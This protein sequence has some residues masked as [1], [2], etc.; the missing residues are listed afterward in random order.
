MR[1]TGFHSEYRIKDFE[2]GDVELT[3]HSY[4]DGKLVETLEIYSGP[5]R[6]R[7][8]AALNKLMTD[9]EAYGRKDARK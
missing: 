3:C 5:D 8:V 2:N 7:M 6:P 9:P 4:V 1:H